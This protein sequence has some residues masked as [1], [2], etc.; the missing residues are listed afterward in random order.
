MSDAMIKQ[1]LEEFS[2][3]IKELVNIQPR[4][5]DVYRISAMIADTPPRKWNAAQ[6]V[7]NATIAKKLAEQTLRKVKAQKMMVAKNSKDLKAAPDRIAW[8][9]NQLDVQAAEAVVIY[10]D[11]ELQAAKLAYECLDDAFTAGKKIMDY[12]T[13]Q[14]Q[15][16]R[17]YQKYANDGARAA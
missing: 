6:G 12:L 10:A 14:D 2:N 3:D 1:R 8:V 13:K 11:G 17:Q 16:E 7:V 4:Q 15:A 9:E 5:F